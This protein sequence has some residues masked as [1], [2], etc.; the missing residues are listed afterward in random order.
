MKT[1]KKRICLSLLMMAL[2]CFMGNFCCQAAEEFPDLGRNG[3]ISVTMKD[4][5]TG[6]IVPG[7]SIMLIQVADA[8]KEDADYRFQYTAEFDGCRFRLDE[9]QSEELA[10]NLAEYADKKGIT[11]TVRE[12]ASDGTVSFGNLQTG[13]YL[14]VQQTAAQGYNAVTPFLVSVPMQAADGSGW[15]YDVDAGP[16]VELTKTQTPDNPDDPNN[17]DNPND[18]NKPDTP[19]SKPYTPII[20]RLPQTGQLNWPIPVMTIAGLLLLALGWKMRQET[21]VEEHQV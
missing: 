2:V 8:V 1:W 13:L 5:Q 14:L 15:V 19:G 4:T 11:G 6:Q 21:A 16:K 20:E 9:I 10:V 7:G 3:S 12:I 17:P 18:P